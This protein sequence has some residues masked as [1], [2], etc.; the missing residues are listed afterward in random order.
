MCY[1]DSIIPAFGGDKKFTNFD[2]IF[3]Y[4]LESNYI[5]S[6]SEDVDMPPQLIRDG[7]TGDYPTDT[8]IEEFTRENSYFMSEPVI[9][10]IRN[11]LLHQ[12][13]SRIGGEGGYEEYRSPLK[14]M[15]IFLHY[16]LNYRPNVFTKTEIERILQYSNIFRLSSNPKERCG[17]GLSFMGWN[18]VQYNVSDKLRQFIYDNGGGYL[19]R[20][21]TAPHIAFKLSELSVYTKDSHGIPQTA[22]P[23]FLEFLGISSESFFLSKHRKQNEFYLL[24]D[25]VRSNITSI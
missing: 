4:L 14:M 18:D 7:H 23:E 6:Y 21:T 9:E 5:I 13:V 11:N 19:P 1:T 16:R 3:Q 2:E 8:P 12:D 10:E 17:D 22:T 20:Q 24:R 25:I 15:D